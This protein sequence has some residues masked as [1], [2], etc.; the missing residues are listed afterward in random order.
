MKVKNLIL[1]GVL[2][3]LSLP[4]LAFGGYT[5]QYPV[6]VSPNSY[7]SGTIVGARRSADTKQYIQCSSHSGYGWCDASDA[8]GA[9][10][11]CYS[12]DPDLVASMESVTSASSIYFDVNS[13]GT[14][15]Y[16]V[17]VNGSA[18]LE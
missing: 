18:Y 10:L 9:K 7:A 15:R 1:G 17:V 16:V 6:Y 12:L 8:Q 11:S 2:A 14:C 3:A 5:S 13:D 4:A